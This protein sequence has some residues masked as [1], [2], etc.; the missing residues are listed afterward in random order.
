[1]TLTKYQD[2]NLDQ[3]RRYV[4]THREDSEAFHAYVDRSKSEGRMVSI[5]PNDENWEEKVTEAI[6]YSTNSIRWY[7]NN[8]E[9]YQNQAQIISEWW[10]NLDNKIVTQY[11]SESIKHTGIAGWKPD[12]LNQPVKFRISEPS[13]EIRQFTALVKYR[14]EDNAINEIEA[15]AIDLDIDKQNL[16]V[17]PNESAAVSIFSVEIV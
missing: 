8:T 9:N 14:D 13:L 4:L 17:W 1:M 2:M 7:C 12:K 10:C 15:V 16:F 3:L 5:K 11:H 6:R